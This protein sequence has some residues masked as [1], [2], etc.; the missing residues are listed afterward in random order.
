MPKAFD[1]MVSSIKKAIKGKKNPKTGKPFTDSDAFAIATAQWKKAHGGKAPTR[2]ALKD[3]KVLEFVIPITETTL[4]GGDFIIKGSAINETT[5]RNNVK[6]IAQEL[7]KAAPSFRNKPL[8]LDHKNEV[9]NI[10][11]RTTEGV[12]YNPIKKAIDFEAKIMD[13]EI[14]KM[15][16]DGRIQDVSIGAR[17]EDLK[18]EKDGSMKAIGLEGMEISLV[19]VGGDPQANFAKAMADN[20]QIKE[21]LKMAEEMVDELD[22]EEDEEEEE[23]EEVETVDINDEI[24][25]EVPREKLNN[26]KK[27]VEAVE[28]KTWSS[29]NKSKLPD[30]S[31]AWVEKRKGLKKEVLK[32]RHLPYKFLDGTLSRRGVASAWATIHGAIGSRTKWPASAV[33]KIKDARNK[34][35]MGK[36][37]KEIMIN[38]KL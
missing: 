36:S 21:I 31:F 12:N 4:A 30:S 20:F 26:E 25:D 35:S 17:V 9:K 8:L 27:E 2:E 15:I 16:S 11:G 32:V 3:W 7:E 10:V 23:V 14:Q 19:A 1:D 29:V 33:E 34:L 18:E 24:D 38:I 6:Y 28:D 37:K 5:T 22:L 13:K